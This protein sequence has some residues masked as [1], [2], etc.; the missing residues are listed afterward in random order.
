MRARIHG[1]AHTVGGSRVEL[2]HDGSRLVLDLGLP[3]DAAPEESPVLPPIPGLVHGN[4]P[5][6]LGVIASK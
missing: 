3:R 1:G 2:E 5:S 4:D 6:L